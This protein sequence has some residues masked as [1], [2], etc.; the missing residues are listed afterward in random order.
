M[1][2]D[3]LKETLL[4]AALNH[5][6][7]GSHETI[8]LLLRH[9]SVEVPSIFRPS[10]DL[11]PVYDEKACIESLITPLEWFITGIEKPKELLERLKNVC[12]PPDLCGKVFKGGE[13]VYNC[14]DCGMDGTCVLCVDC[15]K[16]RYIV[17]MKWDSSRTCPLFCFSSSQ[18]KNHRY[19]I[20]PS[21][22]GYC[23]CGDKGKC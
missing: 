2:L 14:R 23:D 9:W 19:R 13:P 16:N 3:A 18:H 21:S 10:V 1:N 4:K 12:P 22:S 7:E 17:M 15:F 20:C 8:S 5:P 11:N 6:H